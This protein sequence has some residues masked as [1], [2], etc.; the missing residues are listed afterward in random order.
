MVKG[1][2]QIIDLK[3]HKFVADVEV[4]INGIS[5]L[6]E[7]TTKPIIITGLVFDD[8]YHRDYWVNFFSTNTYHIAFVPLS[9]NYAVKPGLIIRI[10]KYDNVSVCYMELQ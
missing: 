10:D 3:Q 7:N 9:L 6:I 8:Y 5:K 2:Y 1:G 4:K